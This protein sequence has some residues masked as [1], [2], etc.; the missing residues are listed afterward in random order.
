MFE[1]NALAFFKTIGAKR[2]PMKEVWNEKAEDKHGHLG[3][4]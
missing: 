2:L 4:K 3:D 1:G